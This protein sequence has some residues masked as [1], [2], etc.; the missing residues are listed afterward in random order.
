M[1]AECPH[2]HAIFR[3]TEEILARA[4]GKVRCGECGVVFEVVDFRAVE[5]EGPPTDE[6][7][8]PTT[9]PSSPDDD[10]IEIVPPGEMVEKPI[11]EPAESG[12]PLPNG[13][14][15]SFD[16]EPVEPV[17]EV[18]P[19]T[20][21]FEL[22]IEEREPE[23]GAAAERRLPP[24][25]WPLLAGFLALL[26]VGQ[27]L[28][29]NR[30]RVV[31]AVPAMRPVVAG[32]CRLAGCVVDPRRDLERIELTSHSV[33]SHPEVDGALMIRATIVNNAD[34]SQPYPVV[35]LKMKNLQGRV[36]AARRFAPAE[37]LDAP[38]SLPELM[39]PGRAV[40]LRLEILDPG[41]NALAFEFDFL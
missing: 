26:L 12:A 4:G 40:P 38:A 10:A 3:V 34:F 7:L 24:L 23:E 11:I 21:D 15:T 39:M 30:N 17:E 36:V 6:I 37:Y 22:I 16:D 14:P 20:E 18:A 33:Y 31:E 32:L 5:D 13:L 9:D 25:A 8:V 41:K 27:L 35:A 29:A 28:V 1:Y 2:C 19:D